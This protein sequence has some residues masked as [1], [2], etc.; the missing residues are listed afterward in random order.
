MDTWADW[1]AIAEGVLSA[2]CTWLLIVAIVA[3]LVEAA[4]K[5]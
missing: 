1:K 2:L 3:A 4:R 5:K